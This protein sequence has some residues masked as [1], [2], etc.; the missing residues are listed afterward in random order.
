MLQFFGRTIADSDQSDAIRV[1]LRRRHLQMASFSVV[2]FSHSDGWDKPESSGR[3]VATDLAP[4][5]QKSHTDQID[6]YMCTR[7][8][9]LH[10]FTHGRSERSAMFAD[11]T[12][13]AYTCSLMSSIVGGGALI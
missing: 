8:R 13:D 4:K 2:T 9:H 6:A 1:G 12:A 10:M 7:D 11:T 5:Q 3:T